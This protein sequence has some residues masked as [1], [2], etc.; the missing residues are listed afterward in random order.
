M[1]GF[2]TQGNASPC[3]SSNPTPSARV[4]RGQGAS[5]R[6]SRSP[7]ANRRTRRAGGRE[8]RRCRRGRWP[9]RIGAAAYLAKHGLRTV[10]C[11]AREVVGGAAVSEH[12]FGPDYTV[13][14]L[15]YVV[16]LLPPTLVSDLQL[17]RHGYHVYPQGPYFAPRRDGR[18]L[19]LPSDP[20]SRREQIAKSP[21][22]MPTLSSG[23]PSGS[24]RWHPSSARCLQ[25]SPTHRLAASG[26]PCPS[27]EVAH[28]A[29]GHRRAASCGH[30]PAADH[31]HR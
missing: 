3:G 5:H 16:S 25:K 20:A 24:T 13:T 19:Q 29:E 8:V 22:R 14:M 6:V 9:Q 30:H 15:S 21:T 17:A 26:R 27:G 28:P 2:S 11:E 4:S 23:G 31:E 18:Y 7:G 12:P 10:V 1:S